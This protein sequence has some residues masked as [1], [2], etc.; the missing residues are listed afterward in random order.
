MYFIL[1]QTG[2]LTCSTRQSM[3]KGHAV[4]TNERDVISGSC[5]QA[6]IRLEIGVFFTQY[7]N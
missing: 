2:S 1:R 7:L 3:R 4:R 5:W 6:V